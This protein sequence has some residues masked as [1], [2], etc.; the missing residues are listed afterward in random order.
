MENTQ[1]KELNSNLY[2]KVQNAIKNAKLDKYYSDKEKI[3]KEGI[4][5]LGGITG[6][7]SLQIEKLKNVKLKIELTQAEKIGKKEEVE[8]EELLADLF[9]CSITELGGKFN[10][11]MEK[12]YK[13]LKA[14]SEKEKKVNSDEYIYELACKKIENSQNYLPII[15]EEKPKGIFGDIRVQ[16]NFLKLENK[17]LENEIIIQRWKSQFETFKNAINK[18]SIIVPVDWQKRKKV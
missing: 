4:S 14:R 12:I 10:E 9:A 13:E 1:K 3:S 16:T 2:I 8:T 18:D 11:E 6:K 5:F 7:N 15:H 17:K